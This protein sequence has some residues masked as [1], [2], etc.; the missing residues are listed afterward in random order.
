VIRGVLDIDTQPKQYIVGF[1]KAQ[2]GCFSEALYSVF[3]FK[4][5]TEFDLPREIEPEIHYKIVYFEVVI[6]FILG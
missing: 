4:N 5:I 2:S 3:N 6:I 1:F